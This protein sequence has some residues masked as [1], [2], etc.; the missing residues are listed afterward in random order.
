MAAEENSVAILKNGNGQKFLGHCHPGMLEVNGAS[1][2]RNGGR[3][4]D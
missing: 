3:D 4:R 1:V 2:V